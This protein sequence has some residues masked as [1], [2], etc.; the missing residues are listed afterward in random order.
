LLAA[1][2]DSTDDRPLEV[3]YLTQAIFAPTC[4]A[5]QCHSTFTQA[6]LMVFDNPK[7]TRE[8][9]VG[10]KSIFGPLLDFDSQALEPGADPQALMVWLTEI[11]P[12]NAK[13][14]RMPYDAPMPNKDIKLLEEW[15]QNEAPGAQCDPTRNMGMACDNLTVVRCTADWNFG[16]RV[17]VCPTSC[18]AGM[19]R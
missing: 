4:G 18:G 13:I 12:F 1:C 11:D 7:G 10:D 3:E 9:L 2:A 8:A 5:A 14:G 17:M 6:G 15:I 16:E 19:C